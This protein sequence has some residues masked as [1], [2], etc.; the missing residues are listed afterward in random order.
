MVQ[1]AV[2]FLILVAVTPFVTF[3]LLGKYRKLR[4]DLDQ[5]NAGVGGVAAEI[6]LAVAAALG[7]PEFDISDLENP[8]DSGP[9]NTGP[10]SPDEGD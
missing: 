8:E 3:Y 5:G 4:V 7:Q 2:I 1:L 9:E 6:D 10:K